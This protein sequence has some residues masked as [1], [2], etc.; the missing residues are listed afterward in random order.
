[1]GKI[2]MPICREALSDCSALGPTLGG[3]M[4]RKRGVHTGTVII[5]SLCNYPEIKVLGYLYLG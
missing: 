5:Y 1:M 4:E 2:P 3:L